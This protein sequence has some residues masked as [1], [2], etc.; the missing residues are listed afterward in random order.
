MSKW[1]KFLG[2]V[3]VLAM[4]PAAV[5]F[6]ATLFLKIAIIIVC[7][8]LIILLAVL[9]ILGKITLRKML[10][11]MISVF[12][13]MIIVIWSPWEK[14]WATKVAPAKTTSLGV[15]TTQTNEEW[16]LVWNLPPN[17]YSRGRNIDTLEVRI[18]KN[19]S[20][21]L[22]FDMYYTYDGIKE[23]ARAQLNKQGEGMVGSWCQDNPRD[24]GFIYMDKVGDQI[25][26]GQ[27]TGQ[28]GESCSCT[29]KRK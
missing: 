24:G 22:Y 9:Q 27:F 7:V 29:L 26:V 17:L 20:D 28:A 13:I 23:V 8:G 25:W 6:L 2:I 3:A 11:W 10:W 21:S 14:S 15:Q 18:M 5:V 16:I 1:L 12:A 4:I 19:D